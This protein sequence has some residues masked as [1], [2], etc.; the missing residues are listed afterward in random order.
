MDENITGNVCAC[1]CECDITMKKNNCDYES[2]RESEHDYDDLADTDCECDCIGGVERESDNSSARITVN[3]TL[4]MRGNV[5]AW[6][7]ECDITIKHVTVKVSV[8]GSA[9]THNCESE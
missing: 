5:C 3:M 4:G 7:C 1:E 9:K 6:E 8:T 2:D